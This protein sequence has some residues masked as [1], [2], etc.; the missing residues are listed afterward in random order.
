MERLILLPVAVR[1]VDIASDSVGV[2]CVLAVCWRCV[3]CVLA[4]CWLFVFVCACMC[5]NVCLCFS[6]V[7]GFSQG[8]SA[9]YLL[10]FL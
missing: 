6:C 9:Y 8:I 1:A 5:V 10:F 4:V 3:G 2:G 7:V